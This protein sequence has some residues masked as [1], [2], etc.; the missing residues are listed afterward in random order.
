MGKETAVQEKPIGITPF[1]H[2]WP[3]SDGFMGKDT[4]PFPRVN[5]FI[6]KV[7]ETK[8]TVDHH[9]ACLVT[10]AYRKNEHEPQVV[11]CA[12]AL[13]NVLEN[14]KINIREDELIVGEMSAPIKCAPIFPEH[15]LN[16]VLDEIDNYPLEKR[17][18][19]QYYMTRYSKK[20]LKQIAGYWKGKSIDEVIISEMSED[21]KKGT[22]LEKGFYLLNLFMYGGIGHLQANYEKLFT[23]GF[24]GLTNLVRDKMAE[25]EISGEENRAKIDF[26]RAELITLEAAAGYIRRYAALAGKMAAKERDTNRRQELLKVADNCEWVAE[27]P[28][29]TFRE[30]LQLL[31]LATTIILIESNGHSVSIGRFDQFMYPF[32]HRDIES[33]EITKEEVQELIEIYFTKHLWWTKLRDRMTV[34]ANSGRGMGGDSLTLGGVDTEGKDATNDLTFMC[35]DAI[36]H[37]RSGVPWI[38]VRWHEYTPWELKVKTANVIRIGTGQPKVFNDQAAIPASLRAGRTLEDSRN[39]HVVGCVEI[40]AGGREYGWH[41]A[42]Y[43]NI[44]KI[45]E[46]AI[47]DGRCIGCGQHCDRWEKC[48][49]IG[50]RLGLQTGS[51]TDFDSFDRVLEAYDKQMDYWVDL[52]IRGIEVMDRVHQRLKPLPYLSNL[53]DDCTEKG[54]DISAGGARY[55]FTGPQA[56][57][58]GTTADGMAAIKQLI[59][60]DGK[61]YRR[62]V[63]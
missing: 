25:L 14:V 57:G 34:I 22:N 44:A 42:S 39:Y 27:N 60:D 11:R 15:S 20:K 21:E 51:L 53:I 49:G 38:A 8:F 24:G 13:A 4:S 28:P 29:R 6:N 30:A 52:M 10:E 47:N 12:L 1:D 18:H 16:W 19:D 35:L 37:T 33:R 31:Y 5:R 43:F 3:V 45:L 32:Y 55:N 59:F 40:D 54:V 46:L 23:H 2:E 7:L 63:P 56:V 61:S 9:R 36:A 50:E 26:Y 41:D 62:A 48:G 58:V 17:L